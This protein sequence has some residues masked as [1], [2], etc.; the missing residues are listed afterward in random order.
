M[1]ACV[2]IL[3]RL[4]TMGYNQK[5]V[6][7][8]ST[9]IVRNSVLDLSAFL[10]NILGSPLVAF[11]VT[12]RYPN[13]I[14]FRCENI[15]SNLTQNLNHFKAFSSSR[16]HARLATWIPR[17][18]KMRVGSSL[19]RGISGKDKDFLDQ[20][21]YNVVLSLHTISRTAFGTL[22]IPRQGRKY[23]PITV[24]AIHAWANCCW[25]CLSF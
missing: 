7:S 24:Q 10:E 17:S 21:K 11:V 23:G 6:F 4:D 8:F 20:C 19:R 13:S 1:C 9:T 22:D 18:G 25:F 15:Q 12:F 14:I 16:A 5:L 2:F 3:N